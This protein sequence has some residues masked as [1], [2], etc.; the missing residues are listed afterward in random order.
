MTTSSIIEST[1]SNVAVEREISSIIRIPVENA[2]S[3][4]IRYALLSAR[5]C[6]DPLNWASIPLHTNEYDSLFFELDLEA[7][8]LADGSYEYEFIINGNVHKPV[9][10]PYAEEITRFGGYRGVFHIK[11][12]KRWQRPFS[13]NDE[14]SENTLLANNNEIVIYEMPL[15]WMSSPVGETAKLRQIG[16]GTFDKV[17]FERL[18]ELAD[19]G[20]NAI[21]LLPVQDSADTLNWGYGTRFFFTTDFDMGPPVDLKFFIKCCHQKG[22]RVFLDIVMNHARECP[23]EALAEKSYFLQDKTEEHNRGDDYGARLFRYQHADAGGIYRAREFHYQAAEFWIQNY[24]IDGFRIDEFRGIANWE[25]IQTFTKKITEAFKACFPDRPFL[26]IAEDSWRRTEIVKHQN[27]NPNGQKIVDSM[28]NFAFRDELRRLMRND[29]Q[30]QWGQPSRRERIKAMI[31]GWQ[32]WDEPSKEFKAGFSDMAQA[33]NYITSHDVEKHHEQRYF[34]FCFGSLLRERNLSDGNIN[35]IKFFVDNID[36]QSQEI[37][38]AN[39]DAL[40]MSRSAQALLLTSIGI[41][42]ILAGE[43]FADCHDLDNSDWRLKMSDPIDWH[44]KE[45]HG[46]NTVWH[47]VQELINL[48]KS[49]AALQRNEIDFFYFHPGIDNN[50]GERVFAY[51]RTAN[52]PLGSS[53][54][55]VVIANPSSVDYPVFHLPWAWSNN[56]NID[57]IATPKT[58]SGSEFILNNG[59]AGFSLSSFQVRVFT[60]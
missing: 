17:I 41:P 40:E 24:H 14:L 49:H 28:W 30:T 52:K 38:Q 50:E 27:T 23:L 34:S 55:V 18:N 26:V 7:Q 19:L 21:E 54:Q 4:E 51:C 42:M 6:F 35:A 22:I 56:K 58:H 2:Q 39:N 1:S 5:D 32:T 44:R 36:S 46:H 43:E 60:T 57:E 59:W 15:R 3:V 37:Q 33:V 45:Y 11:N 16:L 9:A 20:I 31:A 8:K 13:W 29:I 47:S 25:F 53:G 10:D 48:R 12:S